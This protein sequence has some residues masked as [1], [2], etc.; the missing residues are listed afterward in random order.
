MN[1][2]L[3]IRRFGKE[4]TEVRTQLRPAARRSP[5]TPVA[6]LGR[7]AVPLRAPHSLRAADAVVAELL[8]PCLGQGWSVARHEDYDGDLTLVLI[9]DGDDEAGDEGAGASFALHRA[10]AGVHLA[11]TRGD[12]Y[13]PLGCFAST[14]AALAH[15]R[16]VLAGEAECRCAAAA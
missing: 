2:R 5:T 7:E 12:A 15:V 16:R 13:E 10:A 9:P 4:G 1:R 14:A 8:L 6:V 3:R 11:A